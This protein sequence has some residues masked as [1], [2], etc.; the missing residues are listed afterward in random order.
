MEN[1]K[2]KNFGK[3]T[4]TPYNRTDIGLLLTTN[5]PELDYLYKNSNNHLK[6]FNIIET[7]R[8][9]AL[10]QLRSLTSLLQTRRLREKVKSSSKYFTL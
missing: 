1:L 10:E 6:Q 8:Q 5:K 2:Q 9:M 3:L 7:E 4:S